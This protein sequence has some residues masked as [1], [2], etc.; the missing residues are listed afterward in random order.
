MNRL[1]RCAVVLVLGFVAGCAARSPHTRVLS[2]GPDPTER[3]VRRLISAWQQRL[4]EYL[5]R[6]GTLDLARMSQLPV[7]R[8]RDGLRPAR[9]TFAALDLEANVPGRDGWDVTGVLVGTYA[10]GTHDWYVFVVGM[11]VRTGYRPVYISDIRVTAMSAQAGEVHWTSGPPPSPEAVQRYR[12][13]FRDL[14]P[15]QYPADTDAYRLTSA[16]EHALVTETQ[17]GAAWAIEFGTTP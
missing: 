13:T 10:I 3:T 15:V 1:R 17:S 6:D 9:I 2:P 4:T 16:Q 8:S 7:L 5:D 12:D 14:L 11:V